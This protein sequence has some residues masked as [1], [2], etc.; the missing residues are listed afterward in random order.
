MTKKLLL[1]VEIEIFELEV[2][3][4]EASENQLGDDNDN[5]VSLIL[6]L[7][8]DIV[9]SVTR[10][11]SFA[12]G[13]ARNNFGSASNNSEDNFEA[14]NYEFEDIRLR[15][16]PFVFDGEIKVWCELW[17]HFSV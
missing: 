2:A 8:K 3:S 5:F 14:N 13:M 1:N 11:T 6:S 12:S 15:W 10:A 9:D 17:D 16:K 4:S 7:N